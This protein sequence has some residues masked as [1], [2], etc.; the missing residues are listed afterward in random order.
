MS[1]ELPLGSAEFWADPY[2]AWAQLRDEHPVFWWETAAAW[3]VLDHEHALAVLRDDERFSPSRAYW[4]GYVEPDPDTRSLH[5]RV[6]ETGLFQVTHD[7]H[8]RLRRLVTKAFTP[9]GVEDQR[10]YVEEAIA[11]L[12][13]GRLAG[14]RFDLAAGLAE[15]LPARVIGHL[16]GIPEEESGRF[17]AIA[18]S[19]IRGLDPM[20]LDDISDEIDRDVAELIGLLDRTIDH[21]DPTDDTLLSRL[22]AVEEE[23]DRLSR[24]ELTSLVTTLLVAGSD[25]TVHA[26]TLGALALLRNRGALD[27][28]LDGSEDWEDA[29]SELLRFSYIGSGVVRYARYTSTIAG[30]EVAAGSMVLLNLAAAHHD[31]AVFESPAELDLDR[32]NGPAFVFGAGSHYCIGAA[33]A[34]LEVS[35]A[36]RG[37]F[38]RFPTAHLDGDPTWGDHLVLRGIKRLP[39]VL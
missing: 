33:L 5:D 35:T 8:V 17:K 11:G 13:A 29:V 26:I 18:D 27:R 16:L 6:F 34:R 39:V 31:P 25:T 2:P 30:H 24:E 9:R 22:L 1:V 7:D 12:L 10:A 14:D 28:L 23:G 15:P 38:E 21:L 32:D 37:F 36:L 19:M 20:V 4:S 3:V